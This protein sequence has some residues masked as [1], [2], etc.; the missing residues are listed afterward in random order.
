MSEQHDEYRPYIDQRID[1]V[2]K[3]FRVDF[4]KLEQDIDGLRNDL[5]RHEND[6]QENLSR[7]SH[8]ISEA[9]ANLNKHGNVIDSIVAERRAKAEF[10]STVSS[11][12]VAAGVW[13]IFTAIGA[14]LWYAFRDFIGK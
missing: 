11:Q 12:V 5:L 2:Y 1:G 13:A 6:E 9:I 8:M 7:M 14:I 4:R 3:E 10:W